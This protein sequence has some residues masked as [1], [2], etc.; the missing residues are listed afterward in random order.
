MISRSFQDISRNLR[1]EYQATRADA[2]GMLQVLTGLERQIADFTSR[3]A[4]F[5]KRMKESREALEVALAAKDQALARE[6]HGRREIDRL[7]VERKKAAL[8][9]QRDID[10]ATELSLGRSQVYIKTVEKNLEDLT[11]TNTQLKI[12]SEFIKEFNFDTALLFI[13]TIFS[14]DCKPTGGFF[15]SLKRLTV[16]VAREDPSSIKLYLPSL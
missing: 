7:V 11:Y 3:E 14:S 10:Q 4:D 8:D 2:E 6:E 13:T 1:R 12:D 16:L 15:N 9:R 5:E